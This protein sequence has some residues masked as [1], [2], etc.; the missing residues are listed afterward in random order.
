MAAAHGAA[1]ARPAAA[2]AKDEPYYAP[3][4]E[5]TAARIGTTIAFAP[6]VAKRDTCRMET[7]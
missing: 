5:L 4:P 1:H 7:R 3:A 2:V 6:G